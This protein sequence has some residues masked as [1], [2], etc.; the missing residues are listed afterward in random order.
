[1]PKKPPY[2][3]AGKAEDLHSEAVAAA[4]EGFKLVPSE[5]EGV[6]SQDYENKE[7]LYLYSP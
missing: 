2:A 7:V 4:H 6:N 5:V 1:M 3:S